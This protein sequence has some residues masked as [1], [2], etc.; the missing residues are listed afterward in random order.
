MRK[1][2]VCS[3]VVLEKKRDDVRINDDGRHAAGS[4]L[5]CPRHSRMALRKSS[6]VSSSGQKS[7][8]RSRG[9]RGNTTPCSAISSSIPGCPSL[10]YFSEVDINIPSL[11]QMNSNDRKIEC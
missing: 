8:R 11:T 2:L 7:P 6:M 1:V 4:V 5:E 10:M 9:S 3:A